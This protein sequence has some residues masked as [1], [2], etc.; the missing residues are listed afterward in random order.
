MTLQCLA[1]PPSFI[2]AI[3]IEREREDRWLVVQLKGFG[4][5]AERGEKKKRSSDAIVIAISSKSS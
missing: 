2:S 5:E 4:D 3:L 1:P